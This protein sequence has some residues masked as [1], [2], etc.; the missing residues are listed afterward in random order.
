[1]KFNFITTLIIFTT[2]L[3]STLSCS[4][5]DI[6]INKDNIRY[7]PKNILIANFERRNLSY[8]PFIIDNFKDLLKYEFYKLGYNAIILQNKTKISKATSLKE[9]STESLLS[10]YKPYLFIQGTV[11]E[12]NYGDSIDQDISVSIMLELFNHNSK[13]IGKAIYL[14]SNTLSD[15]KFLRKVTQSLAND[16]IKNIEEGMK[17]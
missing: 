15:S 17:K 6:F 5:S 4:T 12:N 2:I 3:V 9:D 1:M 16:I 8:D 11:S 14:T 13:E 7:K 10:K